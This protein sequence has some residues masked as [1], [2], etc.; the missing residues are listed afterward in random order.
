M[1]RF[2]G[3]PRGHLQSASP[4]DSRKYLGVQVGD[5]R[6]ARWKRRTPKVGIPKVGTPKIGVPK[7]GI[8]KVGPLKARIPKVNTLKVGSLKAR[9]P[10]VGSLKARIL[11]VGILTVGTPKVG[12]PKVGTPKVG[13]QKVGI[14]KVGIPKVG[15]FALVP[16]QPTSVIGQNLGKVHCLVS[17]YPDLLSVRRAGLP[18]HGWFSHSL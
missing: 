4:L 5:H 6:H 17:S 9:I 2:A 13:I 8:P 12:T 14:P 1:R 3:V 15:P 16:N 7:I 18:S 11:K 10:K